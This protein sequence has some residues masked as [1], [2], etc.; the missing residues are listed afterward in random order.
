MTTPLLMLP[1][2]MCDERMWRDL[3]LGGPTVVH[4]DLARDDRIDAMAARA[5]ATAPPRFV[6]VGFSMGGIAA[7][8]IA[9]AA[10]KRIAGLVLIDTTAN[11][12]RP[13]SAAARLRQQA[14]VR[15][16]ELRA[17]VSEELC[18]KYLSDGTAG[19]ERKAILD[20]VLDMA[21]TLGGDV[22]LAQSEALRLRA[23]ARDALASIGSRTLVMCGA[24]DVLCT[25]GDHAGLA[26]A[27]PDARL[28]VVPDAGHLLPL[29]RPRAVSAI[30]REFLEHT[31]RQ[32]A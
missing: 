24:E 2:H 6:A 19:S 27:L 32:A 5:L 10:P 18:P 20:R 12:D 21:L 30:L 26:A 13:E 7:I 31:E 4:A 16:G 8:E 23:D 25:P 22:F 29:E 28:A 17:V 14:R 3:D 1:G 15:A 11:P 9:R